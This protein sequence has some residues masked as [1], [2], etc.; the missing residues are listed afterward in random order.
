MDDIALRLSEIHTAVQRVE[1]K[2]DAVKETVQ[3]HDAVLFGEQKDKQGGLVRSLIQFE[4]TVKAIW[5]MLRWAV[6]IIAGMFLL[7][8]PSNIHEVITLV[9]KWMSQ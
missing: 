1:G 9:S 6:A 8:L 5:R 3:L 4:I 2:V 7:R